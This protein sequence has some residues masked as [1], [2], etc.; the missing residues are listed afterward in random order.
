MQYYAFTQTERESIINAEKEMIKSINKVYELFIYQLSFL[1]EI[2]DF[3]S[4][5]IEDAKHKHLPSDSEINPNIHFIK[6]ILYEKISTNKMFNKRR[7]EFHINWS[8][9]ED[10]IRKVYQKIKKSEVYSKYMDL[11]VSDFKQ[12]K[13][14]IVQV[15]KAWVTSSDFLHHKYEELNIHW[16]DDFYMANNLVIKFLNAMEEKWVVNSSLPSL[17]KHDGEKENEDIIFVKKLLIEAINNDKANE[18][19]ISKYLTN[20]EPERI[21]LLDMLIMKLALTELMSFPSIPIKASLN[22]Y[23][24]ISKEY[25]TPKSKIFINGV[26]DRIIRDLKE[27][28]KI[29]KSGRGLKEN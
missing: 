29:N 6:N 7:T 21:A 14:F 28:N 19:I 13:T 9:N 8:D 1:V 4:K 23:I 12:D 15:F 22:E 24:E 3:A 5:T 2:F 16:H 11:P 18:E 27:Q 25:S 20:W 26:L 10:V 17:Y